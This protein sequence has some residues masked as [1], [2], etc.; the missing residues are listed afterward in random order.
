MK[1]EKSHIRTHTLCIKNKCDFV[2]SHIGQANK[3]FKYVQS[4][5][6]KVLILKKYFYFFQAILTFLVYTCK[7]FEKVKI[8][9]L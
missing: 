9:N 6:S 7:N 8:D 2:H 1:L 5:I 3:I 4:T